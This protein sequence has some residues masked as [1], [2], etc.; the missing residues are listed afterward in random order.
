MPFPSKITSSCIWVAIPVN[1]VI[2]IGMPVVRKDGRS[3]ERA[4]GRVGV[5]GHVITKISG[6][7]R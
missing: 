4:G 2:D 7:G 3:V 1:L 6:M 5:K